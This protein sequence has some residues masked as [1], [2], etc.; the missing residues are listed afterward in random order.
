LSIG[1]V[2]EGHNRRFNCHSIDS[3]PV[4]VTVSTFLSA[5]IGTTAAPMS[6]WCI[7]LLRKFS[8]TVVKYM[9]IS[10]SFVKVLSGKHIL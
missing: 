8:F 5:V 6:T 1:W 4:Q 9:H 3:V 10:A 7:G 2:Q